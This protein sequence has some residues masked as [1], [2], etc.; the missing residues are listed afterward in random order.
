MFVYAVLMDTTDLEAHETLVAVKRTLAKAK[1]FVLSQ[2]PEGVKFVEAAIGPVHTGE[3][4][5]YLAGTKPQKRQTVY[6]VVPG[7][8]GSEHVHEYRVE[9]WFLGRND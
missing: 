4:Y 8:S 5:E 3:S 9:K 1:A 2:I 6:R 7:G